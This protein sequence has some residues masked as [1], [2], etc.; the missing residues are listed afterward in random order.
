MGDR[1]WLQVDQAIHDRH[2]IEAFRAPVLLLRVRVS[3][4]LNLLVQVE[5]TGKYGHTPIVTASQTLASS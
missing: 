1:E 5:L 2:N 4:V 3:P